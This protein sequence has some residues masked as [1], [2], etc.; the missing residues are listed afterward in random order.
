MKFLV[1]F[2]V[3]F[4]AYAIGRISHIL[5]GHWNVPH[6]WIYGVI[7]LITGVIY[8]NHELGIYLI[9]FGIGHTTSDLKDMWELKFYGRDEPGPKKVLG[10]RLNAVASGLDH[11]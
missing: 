4:G 3:L 7:S 8:H 1:Y 6:H 2:L 5:A 9:L 11:G 10:Y